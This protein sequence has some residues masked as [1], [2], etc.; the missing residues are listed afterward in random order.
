MG[1]D[2]GFTFAQ[3]WHRKEDKR[4]GVVVW[5]AS[6]AA[7][8]AWCALLPS[9]WDAS[10]GRS[11]PEQRDA[12]VARGLDMRARG[13]TEAEITPCSF[14]HFALI[15]AWGVPERADVEKRTGEPPTRRCPTVVER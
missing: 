10:P 3:R 6:A 14:E 15:A 1:A 9:R 5:C 7:G 11:E 8:I 4:W 13:V 2:A 12:Q